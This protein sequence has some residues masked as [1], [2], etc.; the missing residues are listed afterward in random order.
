MV[1]WTRAAGLGAEIF[2]WGGL[3]LAGWFWPAVGLVYLGFVL[4]AVDLWLEPELRTRLWWRVGGITAVV[5]CALGFSIAFVFV[6]ARLPISGIITDG[7]YPAG[8]KISGIEWKSEFTELTVIIE[9]PTDRSYEDLNLVIRPTE[10]V[11]AIA[12]ATQVADVTFED[13]NG[14][15]AHIFDVPLRVPQK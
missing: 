4:L 10:P 1:K 8:T 9:N 2:G 5:L 7:E 11:A 12:Q 13:K 14:F 6:S 3:M 15:F